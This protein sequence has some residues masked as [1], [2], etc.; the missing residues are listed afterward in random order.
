ML[1]PI[2][3]LVVGTSFIPRKGNQTQKI[4]PKTEYDEAFEN[5]EDTPGK[6]YYW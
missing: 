6:K 5:A 1:P 3:V 4:P 2:I